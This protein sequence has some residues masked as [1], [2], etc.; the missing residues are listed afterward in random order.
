MKKYKVLGENELYFQN[1]LISLFYKYKLHTD[2]DD[3]NLSM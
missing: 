3:G 1:S 2:K